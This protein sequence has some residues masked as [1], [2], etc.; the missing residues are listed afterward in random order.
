MLGW[1]GSS[2]SLAQASSTGPAV[3][4]A[5][6]QAEA[7]SDKQT[8]GPIFEPEPASDSV[9]PSRWRKSKYPVLSVKD[10]LLCF[11]DD[12]HCK[13]SLL[14]SAAVGAGIRL[15]AGEGPHVP[16]AQFS[17]RGGLLVRPFMLAK[18]T[19]HAWGVGVVA[20]WSRGTGAVIVKGNAEEQ[21]VTSTPR[22]DAWRIALHNRFS[23]TQ[24]PYAFHLDLTLGTVRSE[25]LATGKASFGTHAEAAV[26]WS[27]WINLF[28]A[29]DFLDRDTRLTLGVR[30]HAVAA[31]PIIGLALLGLALGGAM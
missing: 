13:V 10:G 1:S 8:Y 9:Y 2:G 16:Y 27:E 12:A 17:F 25:V 15:S 4:N 19:W 20:G 21:V 23:L 14:M 26:G 7:S 30:G 24:K 28:V 31:G 18:T 6:P 29:G 11:V 3:T 5:Q 22:T